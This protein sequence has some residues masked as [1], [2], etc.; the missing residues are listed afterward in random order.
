MAVIAAAV[1]AIISAAI[2]GC[3]F[4]V[5]LIGKEDEGCKPEKRCSNCG[6]FDKEKPVPPECGVCMPHYPVAPKWIPRK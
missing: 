3:V 6:R 5:L 4:A 1:V 2:V